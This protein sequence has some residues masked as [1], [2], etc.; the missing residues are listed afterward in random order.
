M[1]RT[2]FTF[3]L[4]S[5]IGCD[6]LVPLMPHPVDLP[7]HRSPLSPM[8]PIVSCPAIS[9]GHGHATCTPYAP[10]LCLPSPRCLE[11]ARRGQGNT[12]HMPCSPNTASTWHDQVAPSP[13]PQRL[14]PLPYGHGHVSP[15]PAAQPRRP[16]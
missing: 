3:G 9:H 8:P 7:R 5:E 2:W 1:A 11:A 12:T 15:P 16:G 14:G 13:P 6:T 10:S 4:P